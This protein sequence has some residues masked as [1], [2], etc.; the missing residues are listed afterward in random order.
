MIQYTKIGLTTYVE[1]IQ[2]T[3]SVSRFATSSV[4]LGSSRWQNP[5]NRFDVLGDGVVDIND[6]NAIANY[7][8]AHGAGPL[9]KNRPANQPYIDVSGDGIVDSRD[10]S[11][12]LAYL[13]NKKILDT[14]VMPEYGITDIKLERDLLDPTTVVTVKDVAAKKN[15][16]PTSEYLV[17]QRDLSTNDLTEITYSTQVASR[18]SIVFVNKQ[19]IVPV[20]PFTPGCYND[21]CVFRLIKAR[22]SASEILPIRF[23]KTV[24]TTGVITGTG[25][26][27]PGMDTSEMPAQ[28]VVVEQ[29]T[30]T[31]T[32]VEQTTTTTEITPPPIV[33]L[34]IFPSPCVIIGEIKLICLS[35]DGNNNASTDTCTALMTSN[36]TPSPYICSA[37]SERAENN[38]SH[39][40]MYIFRSYRYGVQQ[41]ETTLDPATSDFYHWIGGDYEINWALAGGDDPARMV[42]FIDPRTIP[43]AY[44]ICLEDQGPPRGSVFDACVLVQPLPDGRVSCLQNGE[45]DHT[46]THKLFG[47]NG[48]I[49]FDPFVHGNSWITWEEASFFCPAWKAFNRSS[50]DENDIWASQSTA[51]PHYLQYDF[52]SGVVINKYAIQERNSPNFVGFPRDFSLQ[53]SNDNTNWVTLDTR[54]NI[55]APG[56]AAWSAYFTFNNGAAYRYYR[57]NITAV[58][59]GSTEVNISELKLICLSVDGADNA[60][61][62][63]CTTIMASNTVPDPNVVAATSEYY[64]EYRST[65]YSA[66]KAFNGTNLNESDRWISATSV[67]PWYI[68]YD[69]GAGRAT[70]INK[71]AIQEQNYNGTTVVNGE[72]INEQNYNSGDG[73]PRD[74]SLQ[75]SNDGANWATLD[76]R[77]NIDAP[78]MNAWSPYFT[79][80]NGI[81]YRYYRIYITAVNGQLP[82]PITSTPSPTDCTIIPSANATIR[83]VVITQ[84]NDAERITPTFQTAGQTQTTLYSNQDLVITF[85][86]YDAEKGV[87]SAA[88][89]LDGVNIPITTGPHTNTSIGG[90]N[91]GVAIGKRAAGTHSYTIVATNN[92]GVSTTPQYTCWFT[93]LQGGA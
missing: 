34:D 41:I 36:T 11:Q 38:P 42:G 75:G 8:S 44:L 51:F 4:I 1:V 5:G 82:M 47:P 68:Q 59:G 80:S 63:T 6:Y 62:S 15:I 28:P 43:G 29:I 12:L 78:G 72:I 60:T 91:F 26:P 19:V 39:L 21:S 37:D 16:L 83:S 81:A 55:G 53:G 48:A 23:N 65:Y 30:P 31:V 46:Y 84:Y 3:P 2:V 73:F 89:W 70:A 79:F 49:V 14:T 27:M 54:N 17:F 57:L 33:V 52:H 22:I 9:P 67:P 40:G 66:W 90:V 77:V 85:N 32:Y 35:T 50:L 88:L 10:I 93:V 92:D 7:I 24:S 64:S 71:Y 13:Q 20:H 69:F 56:P 87:Y 18:D 76:T 58:V 86:A 61:T 45:S 74:F 25:L